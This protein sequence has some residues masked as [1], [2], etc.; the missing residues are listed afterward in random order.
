MQDEKILMFFQYCSHVP[1]LPYLW[2]NETLV[3]GKK[4]LNM[5][6]HSRRLFGAIG[7]LQIVI[8]ALVLVTAGIH[9]QHGLGMSGGGFRG[10]APGGPGGVPG[11]LPGGTGSG[12]PGRPPGGTGG[13]AP[14]GSILQFI[15][16]P[17]S[18]LFILNGIGYLV[19]IVALY[20][21]FLYR[22]QRIVRWLLIVFAAT[23]FVLY[24]LVNGFHLDTISLIDKV[25]EIAL[26]VLLVID[27]R[28]AVRSRRREVLG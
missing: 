20:L 23:T 19:L 12:F 5:A 22:F 1:L 13:G 3:E 14:G 18:T 6:Y 25:A 21:P 2:C 17:L 11:R 4:K 26:I 24:F 27:D 28:L 16:L 9:L 10:G 8:I 7:I 15:P